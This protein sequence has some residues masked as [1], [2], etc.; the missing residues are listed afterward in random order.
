METYHEPKEFINPNI[1]GDMVEGI[2]EI[3]PYTH[4][5]L[6][7][8]FPDLFNV[9]HAEIYVTNIFI[10]LFQIQDWPPFVRTSLRFRYCKV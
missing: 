1:Y 6:L 3:Q 10:E 9:F 2:L 5:A 7:E 4:G 8:P